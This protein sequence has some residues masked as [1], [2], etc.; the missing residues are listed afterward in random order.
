M[1]MLPKNEHSRIPAK[2]YTLMHML[3]KNNLSRIPAKGYT[4]M[5]MLPKN[6]LSRIPAKGYTLMQMRI[7]AKRYTLI[8]FGA[9]VWVLPSYMLMT[10]QFILHPFLN[11]TCNRLM[12]KVGW[13]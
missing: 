5:H 2:G 11:L 9:F 4:F 1:H 13:E 6:E 3:P 10:A 7:P 12:M 8:L